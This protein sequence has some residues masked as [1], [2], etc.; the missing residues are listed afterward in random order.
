MKI[1]FPLKINCGVFDCVSARIASE[2]SDYFFISGLSLSATQHF[3]IDCGLHS[4]DRV[5]ELTT[6]IRNSGLK[7]PI[8]ADIDDSFG[9]YTLAGIYCKKL[10]AAGVYGVVIED[11]ARP[12]KC[13]HKKGK[14]L[15]SINS[16]ME[17]LDK[18]KQ[19][20]PEMFVIA[21][22]DAETLH[23][24]EERTEMLAFASNQGL[25]DAVQIEGVSNIE[26]IR[27]VR[28]LINNDSTFVVNH[29]D[30]G[31]LESCS[32]Y[33]L[34]DAGVDILTLSTFMIS[35]YISS[36]MMA[37]NQLNPNNLPS[38]GFNLK[39]LDAML[40]KPY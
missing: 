13:G 27:Q 23:D 34:A 30:G 36:C 16:Y 5:I 14:I 32:T 21:R 31:R 18:I 4:V 26:S 38:G 20:I 2:F 1:K 24:V 17:A 8:I 37:S 29:V 10:F 22:S 35:N 39:E 19:T 12:R 9:D 15:N 33:S 3:E 6:R 11:Q 28:S 40:K 25:A 7:T